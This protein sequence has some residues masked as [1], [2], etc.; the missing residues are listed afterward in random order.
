MDDYDFQEKLK[1]ARVVFPDLQWDG[2]FIRHAGLLFASVSHFQ[3]HMASLARVVKEML[4]ELP[5]RPSEVK[6]SAGAL[7][8]Y[9]RVTSENANRLRTGDRLIY[10][11]MDHDGDVFVHMV[12]D[13]DLSTNTVLITTY[14]PNDEEI[15]FK[16]FGY[17]WFD[18]REFLYCDPRDPHPLIGIGDEIEDPVNFLETGD[19]V[20]VNVGAGVPRLVFRLV[21]L[22]QYDRLDQP[23]ES[24]L[25]WRCFKLKTSGFEQRHFPFTREK[26]RYLGNGT[27]PAK[28]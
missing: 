2:V 7:K 3:E 28:V 4:P 1:E 12:D 14:G 8:E 26:Y 9:E 10:R 5:E 15:G 19:W 23:H 25:L 17:D 16:W 20:E 27:E 22:L 21:E 24:T 11:R 6:P 18:E 13:F